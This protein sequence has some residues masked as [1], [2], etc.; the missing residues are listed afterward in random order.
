MVSSGNLR[1]VA[2]VGTDVSEELSTSFT[3][4]AKI[5]SQRASVASYSKCCS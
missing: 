5:S 1:R 3:H 4:A 2:F